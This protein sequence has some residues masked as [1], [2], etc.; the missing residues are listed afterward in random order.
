M[1]AWMTQLIGNWDEW[2]RVAT[3]QGVCQQWLDDSPPSTGDVPDQRW[4][5]DFGDW[6]FDQMSNGSMGTMMWDS[7]QAMLQACLQWIATPSGNDT[8]A[9]SGANATN[10]WC[11][12]MIA[13][14]TQHMGNWDEWD[15]HMNDGPWNTM[16]SR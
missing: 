1:I 6:M 8:S 2:Q 13:W 14:M 4:C 10:G 12:Q 7:P 3:S 5:D 15:D 9:T 11:N 16:M